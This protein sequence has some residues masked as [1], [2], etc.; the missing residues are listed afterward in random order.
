[1][2]DIN[3]YTPVNIIKGNLEEV[4]IIPN[5]SENKIKILFN[6]MDFV[7][8]QIIIRNLDGSQIIYKD[9]FNRHSDCVDFSIEFLA[10]GTYFISLIGPK[11]TIT[12]K[13]IINR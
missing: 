13:L 3:K 4:Q 9:N 12:Q 6:D 1:M 8:N 5:P 7:I 2:L 11:Q 10:S